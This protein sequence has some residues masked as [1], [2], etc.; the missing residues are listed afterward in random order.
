MNL[1]I[2]CRAFD[3]MA[4]G[5][6]RQSIALANEMVKRGHKVGFVTWDKEGAKA[7]YEM[8]LA[9]EWFKVGE[10]DPTV[11]ASISSR[12]KRAQRVRQIVKDFNAD[13]ILGFQ[14][15]MYLSMRVYLAGTGI[16]VIAAERES[17]FR[18]DF[19]KDGKY[20]NAIY[21]SFRFA[22]AIT[23][24]CESYVAEY[25][26]YLQRKMHV[27]P[28]PVF[29][30]NG[31][32]K[33]SG[34]TGKEKQLLCVARLGFAKNQ[35]ALI[36]AFASIANECPEWSLLCAG[37][38]DDR[39]NLKRLI[40]ELNL[41]DRV[42]LPGAIKDVSNL[43]QSSQLFCLP[44]RWEGFPNVLGEALA[45]GL[46]AV[47]YQGCGGVRD[48]IQHG[49]NGLLAEGNGDIESLAA[50]LKELILDP[51]KREAMGEKARASINQYQPS[52]IYDQWEGFLSNIG[53]RA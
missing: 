11:K 44:S 33:P 52:I 31:N 53:K 19:I 39:E 6:E 9:V 38:G 26:P 15:G 37:E 3:N 17:P 29:A 51:D 4:G 50:C 28:N 10:N 13:C 12:L 5:V 30:T 46:P 14:Q 45:H 36:L 23:V 27:I 32:A 48:L 35:E 2:A 8:E 21:Q 20:K 22:K 16:P 1:I 25:P 49:E 41:Q 24:Q 43:Y 34:E 18:Y 7:F 40:S 47:G 42:K